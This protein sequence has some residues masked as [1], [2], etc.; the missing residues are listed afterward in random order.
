MEE[1]S[2]KRKIMSEALKL[3][4][5]KGYEAVS[6]A[7]IAEAVGIKAPS[8]YKHYKSKQDI[9]DA[10]LKEMSFRYERQAASMQLN[11]VKPDKDME[12]FAGIDE[13]RLIEMGK[14]L[15]SYFLHDE[16]TGLFR[17]ML[18]V[19]QFHSKELGALFVK[20]YVDE[21][22]S[23]QGVLFGLLIQ[24]GVFIPENPNVMALHFFAPMYL[25][26][27]LCDGHPERESE[28]MEMLE[29]H[30][31]QFSRLYGKKEG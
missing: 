15:F 24:A 27:V 17:K 6:V 28:A 20:Q 25:L 18:T 7:Q 10:I 4:A 19:E 31:R 23:Y 13:E 26:L 1:K 12:L 21:P 14:G 9:F 16:Y 29:Q 30:I 8:L 2:T 3:F 5:Q 22:L 11:G